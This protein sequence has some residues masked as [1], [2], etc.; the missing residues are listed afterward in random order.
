MI[1]LVLN[2]IERLQNIIA[3]N[4]VTLDP[5]YNDTRIKINETNSMAYGPGG[6]MPHS[7]RVSNNPYPEPNQPN[8]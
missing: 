6:S 2:S 3:L 5:G 4:R 8:S 1:E 7:Q